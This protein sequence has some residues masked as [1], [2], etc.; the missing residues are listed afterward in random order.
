MKY[1]QV[2]GLDYKDLKQTNLLKL[3]IDTGSEKPIYRKSNRFMSHSEL[4]ALKAET[5]E[6]IANGQ[7]IPTPGG[8]SSGWAFPVLYVKKKTGEKRLCVQFQDLNSITVQDAWPLPHIID[9]LESYKGSKIFS[10]LD[11]LKG[12]N[13][14]AVDD[15]TIPK[16]TMSTPWGLFS[17]CV[18]PFGI[19]SGPAVFCRMI[20]LAME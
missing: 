13:Q 19:K 8:A 4:D 3:S 11:L 16:L 20:Y 5:E 12:F 14:I 1:K 6:M 7:I 18:M 10:T 17:Y 2:F 15:D 9:L